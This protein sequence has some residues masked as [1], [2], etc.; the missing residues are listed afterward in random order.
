MCPVSQNRLQRDE[1]RRINTEQRSMCRTIEKY[2]YIYNGI[3][4]D[5]EIEI[6]R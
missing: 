6:E 4:T 2:I 3:N 1:R 5:I